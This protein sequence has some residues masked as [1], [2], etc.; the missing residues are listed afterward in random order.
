MCLNIPDDAARA[1]LEAW[2]DGLDRAAIEALALEG[3]R[4]A[5]FG[6]ATVGRLFGHASRWKT[7]QWL[8]ARSVPLNYTLEDL[9]ADRGALHRLFGKSE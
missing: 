2:G 6:S 4:S 9:E 1:L 3:Y 7:E 5:K 8:A